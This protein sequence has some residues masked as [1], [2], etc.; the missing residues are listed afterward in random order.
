MLLILVAMAV[1]LV[2][3]HHR[4]ENWMKDKL[5]T[6]NKMKLETEIVD[7]PATTAN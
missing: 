2:P 1:I 6:N 5:T 4:L 3:L 7:V